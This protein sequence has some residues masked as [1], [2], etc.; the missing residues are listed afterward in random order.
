M[1]AYAS[2]EALRM[3]NGKVAFNTARYIIFKNND[4]FS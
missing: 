4:I 1:L 2:T 3:T